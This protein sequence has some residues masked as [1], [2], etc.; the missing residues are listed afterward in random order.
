MSTTGVPNG[1]NLSV[2]SRSDGSLESAYIHLSNHKA[3]R[4]E[5]VFESVLLV[6]YDRQG[7]MIGIEI[8]EP[9]KLTDVLKL[10]KQLD[11]AHRA[12]F[13]KFVKNSAPPAFLTIG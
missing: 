13:E 12:A 6:D 4:T 8:L 10:A 7:S 2:N 9:V 3:A 1:F 5:E 11:A